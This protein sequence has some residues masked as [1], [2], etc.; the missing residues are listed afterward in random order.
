MELSE[1]IESLFVIVVASGL[2]PLVV[3]LL[4]GPRIPEV[5]LLLVFGVVIGP[6]VLGV[7]SVEPAIDLIANVGLGL[8][9]FMAGYELDLNVLR[10]RE[11]ATAFA[12]WAIAISAS[13]A[14]VGA[15][16]VSGFVTAFLPVAIALTTTALGT[17]LPLL[18]DSG[19]TGGPFGRAILANGAVGE[20]LPILA[21][22]LFLSA[23]GA[24]HSLALLAA[25][26]IV[27]LLLV[28]LPR[29]L[30]THPVAALVRLG[31]DTSSQTPVRVTVVLLVGLLLL[32]GEL[33]LDVVLG[34]FAAG[35]VLRVTLPRG[36]AGLEHKLEGLAFGFFV[37]AFFV[38]SGMGIDLQS[39][40]DGPARVFVFFVLILA[41]RGLPV[42]V[43]HRRRLPGRDALRLALYA[44]T[45]LPLI[46]AITEI[47]VATGEMRPENAAAL[48]GAGLLS[49]LV[50]P[51]LARSLG[52]V[53]GPVEAPASPVPVDPARP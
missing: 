52:H 14:V 48:V 11:G 35:I 17:L 10:G 50:F 53:H 19:E 8:L 51:L 45:G 36:D 29:W 27:A 39:I 32:A 42:L 9:F 34:A 22:S 37:P 38:V 24:W 47:G 3:G 33:G 44:A 28:R 16:E 25:F 2:A 23:Q 13:L 40:L 31:A 26:G 21:I 1:G 46:V 6:E 30:E 12:A 18:R 43:L 15:L 20:F 41:V 4:P 49:V 5:V 7:A